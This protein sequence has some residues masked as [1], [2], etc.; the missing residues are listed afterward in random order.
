MR[1]DFSVSSLWHFMWQSGHKIKNHNYFLLLEQ[2]C[3][4][5][6]V[7]L[8]FAFINSSSENGQGK[9]FPTNITWRA[10]RISS[11]AKVMA[12][13]LN[14]TLLSDK[15]TQLRVLGAAIREQDYNHTKCVTNSTPGR[16]ERAQIP[17][18]LQLQNSCTFT[19]LHME[20]MWNMAHKCETHTVLTRNR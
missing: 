10:T 3:N 4:I 12:S 13:Y 9:S 19:D 5:N 6:K 8:T 2:S 18:T 1:S 16:E 15:K 11:L 7:C 20:Y 14:H 17:N